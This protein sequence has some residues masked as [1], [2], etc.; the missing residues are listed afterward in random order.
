MGLAVKKFV[1]ILKKIYICNVL[2]MKQGFKYE[3][4][5]I[6]EPFPVSDF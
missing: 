5:T 2:N 1:W 3:T 6:A 4:K